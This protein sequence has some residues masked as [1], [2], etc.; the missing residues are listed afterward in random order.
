MIIFL[1][2]MLM[3]PCFTASFYALESAI[4]QKKFK[5]NNALTIHKIRN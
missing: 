5:R 1:K 4:A 3:L 2:Y